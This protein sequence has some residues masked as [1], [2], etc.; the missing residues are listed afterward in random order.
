MVNHKI[1]FVVAVLF[2]RT[3]EVRQATGFS[4][5]VSFLLA[6]RQKQSRKES[7]V[8]R[9]LLIR[10]RDSEQQGHDY[11]AEETLLKVHL[12][13][14]PGVSLVDA[15]TAVSKYCQAFPFA[16]VL[17]VQPL[18]YLPVTEDG[19]VDVYVLCRR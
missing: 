7:R 1:Y 18:Q 8:S 6:T 16:A 17:P 13:L 5:G 4:L 2:F 11:E 15:K 10:L 3:F 14:Q 9:G 19:G 12:A